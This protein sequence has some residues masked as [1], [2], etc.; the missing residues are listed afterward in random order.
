MKN[1]LV[2]AALLA[3]SWLP[4]CAAGPAATVLLNN[5]CLVTGDPLDGSGPTAD[6]RGGKVGFCCDK[7]LAKWNGLDDAGKRMLFDSRTKEK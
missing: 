5:S 7:C 4:G 2:A 3:A 1:L 6:Y